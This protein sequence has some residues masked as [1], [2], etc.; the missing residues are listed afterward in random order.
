M[1]DGKP[2]NPLLHAAGIVGRGFLLGVGFSTAV[3]IAVFIGQQASS[4]QIAEQ[5]G[6]I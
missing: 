2:K 6:T 5:S 4:H 3:G 1:T